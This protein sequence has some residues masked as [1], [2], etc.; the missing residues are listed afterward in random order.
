MPELKFRPPKEQDRTIGEAV[1]GDF[2]SGGFDAGD[3]FGMAEGALADQEKRGLR[4]VLPENVEDLGREDG[5][6]AVIEREGDEGMAGGNAVGEIGGEALQDRQDD[7]R[8]YPEHEE[9][10]GEDSEGG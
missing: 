5:V 2:V 8:L 1:V 3:E 9:C 6:R 7:E 10:Q 4:V